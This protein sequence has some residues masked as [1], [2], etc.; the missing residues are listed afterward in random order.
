MCHSQMPTYTTNLTVYLS[1]TSFL[2]EFIARQNIP[3]GNGALTNVGLTYYPVH[4][5]DF[6][7]HQN[8][9]P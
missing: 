1:N 7:H 5:T 6:N 4:L 3:L 9:Q 8:K 2:V